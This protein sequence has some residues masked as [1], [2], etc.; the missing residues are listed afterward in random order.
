MAIST[1]ARL[2]ASEGPAFPSIADTVRR[3][4]C[5]GDT[6]RYGPYEL[7]GDGQELLP[8]ALYRFRI[9]HPILG[10]VSLH[11]YAQLEA[12]GGLLWEQEVRTLL[13]LNAVRHPA[14]P[15]IHDGGYDESENLAFVITERQDETLAD[16]NSIPFLIQ[17]RVECVRQIRSLMDALAEMHG[18]GIIHRNIRPETIEYVPLSSDG[19]TYKLR[20][21]HFEMTGLMSNMLRRRNRSSSMA[22]PR[23]RA[24]II[25]STLRSQVY[26]APERTGYLYGEGT[27]NL[28]TERS[29]VFSIGVL[30][31]EIF[32]QP[33]NEVLLETLTIGAASPPQRIAA[34]QD[35]MRSEIARRPLPARLQN[36]LTEMLRLDPRGRPTSRQVVDTITDQYS[37]LTGPFLT[38]E[39]TQPFW[40]MFNATETAHNTTRW[41]WVSHDPATPLGRDEFRSFIDREMRGA[42]LTYIPTGAV[43]YI[44]SSDKELIKAQFVIRGREA[45][46]F[47]APYEHWSRGRLVKQMDHYLL[48]RWV[49]L[50]KDVPD[51]LPNALV[52]PIPSIE[53][54]AFGEPA[55]F[56]AARAVGRPSWRPMLEAVRSVA[57]VDPWVSTVDRATAFFM[58]F[59]RAE[60]DCRVYAYRLKES[61]RT[62]AVRIMVFDPDRERRRRDKSWSPVFR[63]LV[64]DE[65]RRPAFGAF[66]GDEAFEGDT[67]IAL[68]VVRDRNDRPDFGKD[69]PIVTFDERLDDNQIRV[70]LERRSSIPEQGW[71][72]LTRDWGTH[73]A[74]RTEENAR[75]RL[76][77]NRSLLSQL[78]SPL[79]IQGFR[80][81]WDVDT[82]TLDQDGIDH[83]KTI[84]AA[85]T[86]Y[87]I[88]GP[89]GTG[90]TTIA[91]HLV[92]AFL[93]KERA[94]RILISAQSNYALDN[95]AIKVRDRLA[96]SNRDVI[97]IRVA[98]KSSDRLGKVDERLNDV[99]IE[100]IAIE[101]ARQIRARCAKR[102]K[103][104]RSAN[105]GEPDSPTLQEIIRSWGNELP[106]GSTM[107]VEIAERLLRGANVIFAT[108]LAAHPPIIGSDD[109][110]SVFD[111]VIVEEAAKA[112]LTEVA[113]P[114]VNGLRWTL[115]GDHK[116]LLA[117]RLSDIERFLVE[118]ESSPD[119]ELKIH[120]SQRGEYMDVFRYFQRVLETPRPVASADSL[121][122]GKTVPVGVLRNQYRMRKPIA[123][124]VR[125]GFYD[126]LNTRRPNPESGYNCSSGPLA[127]RVL[128]W[129]DTEGVADCADTPRSNP[130]EV[131]IVREV[132][133]KL[134]PSPLA[135]VGDREVPLAILTPYRRQIDELRTALPSHASHIFS[136]HEY[137]GR[138]AR[139]VIASLVRDRKRH[140]KPEEA[141]PKSLGHV[142]EPE[143]VNVLLSRARDML[144]IV[145]NLG[146][147]RAYGSEHWQR[148]CDHVIAQRCVVR[149]EEQFQAPSES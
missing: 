46:W 120:A 40:F 115:I 83:V 62:E 63:K 99:R 11:A 47:C 116:Q 138:E 84:L 38:E 148:I 66:F 105:G 124:L 1:G 119:E 31:W 87:A 103:L 12:L 126:V 37:V 35:Y 69:D 76:V 113:V 97:C 36:L 7:E 77:V 14:L 6:A 143:L 128:V 135:G 42:T 141:Q 137:Q 79:S 53:A 41:G 111:W 21:S 4:F 142:D 86:F 2:P 29:D 3:L 98:S 101:T 54:I 49:A 75:R 112:W 114:L 129:L 108:C 16:D 144:I 70:K 104:G 107:S 68:R 123:E 118:V 24:S 127:N 146:H 43:G 130:G 10:R 73:S 48:A 18:G 32:I 9:R 95:L 136:V 122:S 5:D 67:D 121:R 91:A 30:A 23:I 100:A 82:D 109:S 110:F 33:L 8:G 27:R 13:R 125:V 50:K 140:A 65:K 117:H 17:N 134:V 57:V 74:I 81:R 96:A 89:P 132:L 15:E 44:S 61:H 19:M 93:R 94:G 149:A 147:F 106:D 22:D 26:S 52:L 39:S 25:G 88:Q 64:A 60:S 20:L 80:D 102:L 58:E 45:V 28:E 85:Q 59:Q 72:C 131:R 78:K 90:K 56:Y 55:D 51:P 139:V 92:D 133:S 71:L 34:I 145:G